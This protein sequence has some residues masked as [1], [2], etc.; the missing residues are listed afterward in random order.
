MRTLSA[1]PVSDE[2][3]VT[4]LD[5]TVVD[6]A[7][8]LGQRITQRLRFPVGTWALDSRLGTESVIGREYTP[9]LA[10][11]A[12]TAAIRNEGGNE[13]NDVTVTV[14]YESNMRDLYYSADLDTIYGPMTVAGTPV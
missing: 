10:A 1:R 3:T 11:S 9:A 7:V 8:A 2:T 13:L 4:D 5:G 6:R 14:R 12:L